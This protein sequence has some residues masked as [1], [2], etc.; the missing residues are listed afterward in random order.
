MNN[1]KALNIIGE[2][3]RKVIEKMIIDDMSPK[4]KKK[5]TTIPIMDFIGGQ[6]EMYQRP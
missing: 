5:K 6:N 1:E 4:P 3:I 2:N